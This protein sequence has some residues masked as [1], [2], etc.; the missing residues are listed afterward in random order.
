MKTSFY[1]RYML[2][3][4]TMFLS[5]VACSKDDD[6]AS[7]DATVEILTPAEKQILL[8]ASGNDDIQITFSASN[9]WTAIASYGW[10]HLSKMT[11]SSGEGQS[12]FATI[13]DNT[14]FKKRIATITFKDK[15][16]GK[17]TDVV[18][19]Q[20][21]MGGILTFSKDN[22]TL[23]INN[24]NQTITDTVNVVKSNYDYTIN[25]NADWLSCEKMGSNDDGSV[26]YVF[27]ADPDKLYA[28]TGYNATSTDVSFE[29]QAETRAPGVVKYTVKFAGITPFMRLD[30][31][32]DDEDEDESEMLAADE[33]PVVVLEDL[34]GD[35]EYGKTIHIVS[36]IA[37]ALGNSKPDFTDVTY[38][39]DENNSK[40]YFEVNTPVTLTYNKGTLEVEKSDGQLTFVDEAEKILDFK[41]DIQYP[42]VGT[43]FIS[44]DRSTLQNADGTMLM[45][46]AASADG[47]SDLSVPIQVKTANIENVHF[48]V[49]R[50]NY[51]GAP[52]YKTYTYYDQWEGTDME[53]YNDMTGYQGWG[54][55]EDPEDNYTRSVVNTYSKELYIKSRGGMEDYP[56]LNTASTSDKPRYFALLAV[57][58]DKYSTFD[59]LF[60]ENGELKE[61]LADKYFSL[62]QQGKGGVEDFKCDDLTGQTLNASAAGQ[63]FTFTY[64]GLDLNAEDWGAS[65]CYDVTIE[66]GFMTKGQYGMGDMLDGTKTEW[67]GLEGGEGTITLAVLPNTTGSERKINYAISAGMLGDKVITYFT[68]TQAAN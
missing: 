9:D 53:A 12:I 43:D 24:E 15:V 33:N 38:V 4:C 32:L 42:G 22:S 10:I 52:L 59:D 64:S 40:Q 47:Y 14:E 28:A 27:H 50:Q 7:S 56:P 49:I 67:T 1:F 46:E 39:N 60:D 65:L 63:T 13:D 6:N 17:T 41:L 16:S 19:T 29:Y 34:T 55:V 68:I 36:N 25:T 51:A 8:N 62:G 23:Q 31:S 48:Y 20:G 54:F 66:D 45:F 37:W 21:E 18:I 11:G 61:E 26:K 35:G 2:I 58:A 5:L 44:I 57:P 30:T 3:A